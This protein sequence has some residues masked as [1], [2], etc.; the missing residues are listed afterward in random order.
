MYWKE[1]KA[2]KEKTQLTVH[3]PIRRASGVGSGAPLGLGLFSCI[4]PVIIAYP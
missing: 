3:S 2:G 1:E 4:M